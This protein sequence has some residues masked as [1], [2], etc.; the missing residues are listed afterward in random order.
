MKHVVDRHALG[1]YLNDHLAGSVAGL[2]AMERI[3]DTQQDTPL[4]RSMDA[5]VHRANNDQ[6]VVRELLVFIDVP[7]RSTIGAL[8]WVGEKVSRLK[9]GSDSDTSTP[10]MLFEALE[11]LTL[12]FYGRRALWHVLAAI[13][14]TLAS[15]FD[16]TALA[17]QVEA[18]LTVLEQFRL[19]AAGQALT[20]APARDVA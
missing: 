11:A 2:E 6:N 19:D 3:A 7:E 18:D 5:L 20:A 8:A 9:L 14:G 12:G 16:F 13:S 17:R 1:V 15:R 4:G 10:L